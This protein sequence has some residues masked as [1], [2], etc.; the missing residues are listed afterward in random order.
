MPCGVAFLGGK[1]TC[2]IVRERASTVKM[3]EHS[4]RTGVPGDGSFRASR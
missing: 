2:A 4:A 3:L 1:A